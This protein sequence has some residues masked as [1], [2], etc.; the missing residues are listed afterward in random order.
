[1]KYSIVIPTYNHCND[2]LRPCLESIFK[3]SSIQDI[4]LIISANGCTDNTFEYLGFLKERYRN[5]GY[6]NN[7]KIAWSDSALGFSRAT[8]AGIKLATTDLIILLNN[9]TVLLAQEK[10]HWLNLLAAPFSDQKCGISCVVKSFSEPANQN[11]AIFFCVMIHRRV[12]DTI[13]LLNEEYGIGGGEDTE[14]SILTERAG[15]SVVEASEKIWDSNNNIFTGVFPIYHAGEKTMHDTSLVSDYNDV[16]LTNSLILAKKFNPGWYQWRLS[17]HWE[18]AV[19]FKGDPVA[20]REVTRY[21]WAGKHLLGTKIF[22]LGC[23]SGYGL[24]FLPDNIQYTGLDYDQRIIDV[25]REQNWRSDVVFV[26]ADINNYQ[27][28]F[29]DTIIAFEVIEHLDNGLEIVERLKQ[30]CNRLLITVPMLEPRGHWG[31]HHRLHMLD[32]SYF[33]GFEFKYIA[34]SGEIL[35]EPE[36]RGDTEHINLMLCTW[37]R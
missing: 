8:N 1:M 14:F 7:I 26:H 19:F 24:Q 32:E 34:E 11:F 10:N 20:P 3:Y 15:Y 29:Y 21:S 5:L 16:F 22:E 17:N 36:N 31:P 18:R 28:D 23:S 12:F 37:T 25:A 6:Q 13:G 30:H 33:P 9:D 27:L 2:L 35:D 4:E